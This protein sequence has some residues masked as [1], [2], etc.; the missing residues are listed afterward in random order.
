MLSRHLFTNP[1]VLINALE[2]LKITSIEKIRVKNLIYLED[3]LTVSNGINDC[4]RIT[5]HFVSCFDI[6]CCVKG[7]GV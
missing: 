6:A 5:S 4:K 7:V 2:L 1:E 3:P